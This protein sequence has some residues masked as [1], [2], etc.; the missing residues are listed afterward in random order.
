M[1]HAITHIKSLI[2]LATQR[3]KEWE[4]G[5]EW[6]SGSQ[7]H[8]PVELES[9]VFYW[10]PFVGSTLYT[11]FKI[12]L[13]PNSFSGKPHPMEFNQWVW[14]KL[15]SFL[16]K[17]FSVLVE[18][19]NIKISKH[20]ELDYTMCPCYMKLFMGMYHHTIMRNYS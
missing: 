2:N 3:K 9:A 12:H 14:I 17:R 18:K 1:A 13:L 20:K 8:L 4:W 6:E 16:Q 11:K 7:F 10:D 5:R 15:H 19:V